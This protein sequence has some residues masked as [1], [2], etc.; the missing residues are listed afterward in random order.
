MI[1]YALSDDA[2]DAA[3]ADDDDDDDDDDDECID[4]CSPLMNQMNH[5]YHSFVH[6]RTILDWPRLGPSGPL[7]GRY[8][9]RKWSSE[10]RQEGGG[11]WSASHGQPFTWGAGKK[12]GK[13]WE[14]HEKNPGCQGFPLILEATPQ[15]TRV[16]VGDLHLFGT[17]DR[18]VSKIT[19]MGYDGTIPPTCLGNAGGLLIWVSLQ[20]LT[21][22]FG[23][24]DTIYLGL[25]VIM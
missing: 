6:I 5:Q 15:K 11:R 10:P 3:A 1:Q 18:G 16:D 13:P 24:L 4:R 7:F 2:A 17:W 19:G 22:I 20:T 21:L 9:H 14:N 25:L 8:H 12:G 23:W